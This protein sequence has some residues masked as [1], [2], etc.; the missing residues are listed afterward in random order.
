MPNS[1]H[2]NAIPRMGKEELAALE[3]KI[4]QKQQS[5]LSDTSF[6]PRLSTEELHKLEQKIQERQQTK[7]KTKPKV[8]LVS[9]QIYQD[10][11]SPN[12]FYLTLSTTSRNFSLLK[13][14]KARSKWLLIPL[15]AQNP[16]IAQ[17]ERA[18]FL[19]QKEEGIL[20]YLEPPENQSPAAL[21]PKEVREDPLFVQYFFWAIAQ[22]VASREAKQKVK[23]IKK[24][25]KKKGSETTKLLEAE[26]EKIEK[27]I[28]KSILTQLRPL[29]RW[30]EK[31]TGKSFVIEK[32]DPLGVVLRKEETGELI[33]FSNPQEFVSKFVPLKQKKPSQE[34]KPSPE[35]KAPLPTGSIW[36]VQRHGQFLVLKF[37]RQEGPNLVFSKGQW[38]SFEI[39]SERFKDQGE[40]IRIPLSEWPQLQP[41]LLSEPGSASNPITP[42][43]TENPPKDQTENKDYQKT[44]LEP[45]PQPSQ[46]L[47]STEELNNALGIEPNENSLNSN[48]LNL[49]EVEPLLEGPVPPER[50]GEILPHEK[51]FIGFNENN[52]IQGFFAQVL[53]NNGE[54]LTYQPLALQGNYLP[55]SEP[56]DPSKQPETIEKDE[57]GY[58]PEEI[59][60]TGK[61]LVY[62]VREQ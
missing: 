25:L 12:T 55:S 37:L 54:T 45:R 56:L 53:E 44:P 23:K 48:I 1:Q 14:Y 11:Y 10:K 13:I 17:K 21:L 5:P 51:I 59:T 19:K 57:V 33:E 6:L 20:E 60:E 16:L 18:D 61:L 8:P 47:I 4:A 58:S 26:R 24:E 15:K 28:R 31:A 9:G 49:V 30:R 52:S 39:E 36:R 50:L 2:H 46:T 43:F 3:E 29:S 40:I 35:E 22:R 7:E 27:R 32:I 62:R 34:Q 41:Q 38:A 42:S